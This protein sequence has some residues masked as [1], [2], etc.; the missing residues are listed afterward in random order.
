VTIQHSVSSIAALVNAE[1]IGRGDLQIDHLE[2]LECAGPTALTFIRDARFA[3]RWA[4]SRGAAALMTRGLK[5]E[6]HDA[7]TRALLIVPDA[8]LALSRV[9]ELFAGPKRSA[10]PGR[11]NAATIDGTA[12]IHPSASIGPGCVVGAGSRIGKDSV[13]VA[14]VSVGDEVEIGEG[15]VL[16]PS[17][18]IGDRCRIGS[19]CIIH[20]G[21]VIGADGFG[22][23]ATATGPAKIPH[24]GTVEIGNHVEI[25]ANSCVDRAK[26]GATV[27][28]DGTKIDNLCQ[29]AH[30]CRIGRA[31]LICGA[32][33]L[34]GSASLGD[35]VLLAGQVG[36]A[37][38]IVI[39]DRAVVAAK[40]GVTVDIPAGETWW[41]FPA[42]PYRD[43]SRAY[44]VHRELPE[45]R[46]R[47]GALEKAV[48]LG[49]AVKA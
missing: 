17:V 33:A 21:V 22:Y 39:G 24:I 32:C 45:L 29:I 8:D 9:L 40:S 3:S 28:G 49:A 25:G 46:K 5:A 15:T 38:N 43:A 1:L 23:R 18:V 2:V 6:G 44:A 7:S 36:V 16:H 4:T 26:F 42:F 14:N 34:A 30:N 20:G 48:E 12:I 11:H 41:G 31:C 35:G 10:A 37:D 27:I 13:L 47:L 19:R